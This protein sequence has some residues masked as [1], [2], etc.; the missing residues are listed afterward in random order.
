V[1]AQYSMKEWKNWWKGL[2]TSRKRSEWRS[3]WWRSIY[4][5]IFYQN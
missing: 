5:C 4:C 1:L 3:R 2:G